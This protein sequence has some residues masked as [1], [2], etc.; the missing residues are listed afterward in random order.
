MP[1][2][3]SIGFSSDDERDE[4]GFAF[5]EWGWEESC[6]RASELGYPPEVWNEGD[7][8]LYEVA[9]ERFMCLMAAT[10]GDPS[11]E[12]LESLIEG[13]VR[14]LLAWAVCEGTT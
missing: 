12:A 13:I 10:G 7:E 4:Y 3:I 9:C 11:V 5:E 8:L 2:T 6:Y 14:D 1:T